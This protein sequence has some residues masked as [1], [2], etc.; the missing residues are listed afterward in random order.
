MLDLTWFLLDYLIW[1]QAF[2]NTQIFAAHTCIRVDV[3]NYFPQV[4]VELNGE[5]KKN[6][7][8]KKIC[9]YKKNP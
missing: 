7:L 3:V 8:I 4:Q 5:Q 9:Q 6:R 1:C 2:L